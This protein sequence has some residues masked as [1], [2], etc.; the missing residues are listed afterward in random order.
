MIFLCASDWTGFH[1][2]SRL[3]HK[4]IVNLEAAEGTVVRDCVFVGTRFNVCNLKDVRFERCGFVS[5]IMEGG[6]W[7]DVTFQDCLF[8]DAH[9]RAVGAT[10]LSFPGCSF[11]ESRAVDCLTECDG[12]RVTT[13]KR[14]S[15][16][17]PSAPVPTGLHK[18]H[19]SLN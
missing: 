14:S 11:R 13:S 10:G 12:L 6:V 15:L 19:V 9:F 1:L 3:I 5:T 2:E 17:R 8:A 16:N 7:N 4:G 18:R